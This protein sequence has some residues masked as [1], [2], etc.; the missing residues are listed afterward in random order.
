[1][2]DIK[3]DFDETGIVECE[4]I[5]FDTST[6]KPGKGDIILT[7]KRVVIT[8]IGLLGKVK[9][10][11]SYQ[12]SDI[13]RFN[14]RPQVKYTDNPGHEPKVD[15]YTASSQVEVIFS[16]SQRK[17]AKRFVYKIH[18]LLCTEEEFDKWNSETNLFPAM[19][20]EIVAEKIGNTI[21]TVINA[22]KPQIPGSAT[23]SK[24][25]GLVQGICGKTATCLFCGNQQ[26]IRS[27]DNSN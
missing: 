4:D 21:G 19:N 5:R 17:D 9:E 11:Y 1:M 23:C 22:M 6:D 10:T 24:C 12:M 25:G 7:N 18:E 26:L 14:G 3:L 13:K 27:E 15:I 20:P 16:I 8:R 2:I